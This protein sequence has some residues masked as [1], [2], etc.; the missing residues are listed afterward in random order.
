M[1]KGITNGHAVLSEQSVWWFPFCSGFYYIRTYLS[2]SVDYPYQ[3][4]LTGAHSEH[5]RKL[6]QITDASELQ[7]V[8]GEQ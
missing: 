6:L 2:N 5:T 3:A 4:T 1:R 8:D 7:N